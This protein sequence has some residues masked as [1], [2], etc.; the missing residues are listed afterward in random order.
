MSIRPN[1]SSV[2]RDE[3]RDVGGVGGV[4][5][6]GDAADLVRDRPDRFLAAPADDHAGSL[7]R[8]PP[9]GGGTDP[10]AATAHDRDLPLET[11]A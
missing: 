4:A 10:G 5:G 1:E 2:V 6:H 3:L 7:L 9:R 8:E 11:H